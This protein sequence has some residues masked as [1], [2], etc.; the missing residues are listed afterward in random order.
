MRK[1]F[2]PKRFELDPVFHPHAVCGVI[3]IWFNFWLKGDEKIRT[4][5]KP[6]STPAG[7]S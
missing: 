5:L 7:T 4:P 1:T 2:R 6:S 3:R